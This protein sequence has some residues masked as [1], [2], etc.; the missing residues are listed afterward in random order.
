ME[1]KD[2]SSE[3]YREYSS[4]GTTRRYDA[5]KLLWVSPTGHRIQTADGIVH[6]EPYPV[7]D[8]EPVALSW[9]P[10]EG[11]APVVF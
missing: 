8:G 1:P 2:I 6:H 3:Q 4:H 9:L 5:P 10:K 7:R 11:G